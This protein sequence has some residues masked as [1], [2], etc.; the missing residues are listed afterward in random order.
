MLLPLTALAQ[1]AEAFAGE[2]KNPKATPGVG[3]A[4]VRVYEEQG[5]WMVQGLGNC[6][7][8]PC[9]WQPQGLTV[10][11]ADAPPYGPPVAVTADSPGLPVMTLRLGEDL[12]SVE[13]HFHQLAVPARG[14]AA[15]DQTS[16]TEL[17]RVS[18]STTPLP[19][20]S[21]SRPPRK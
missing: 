8:T 3:L 2:W 11:N 20:G 7:P 13:V 12:L 17:T 9:I 19:P 15:L 4:G 18:R 14:I 1:G 5:R 16:T 6:L 10:K 21:P